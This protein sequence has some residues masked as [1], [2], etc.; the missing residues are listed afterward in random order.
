MIPIQNTDLDVM[1]AIHYNSILDHLK[2]TR[3]KYSYGKIDNWFKSNGSHKGFQDVILADFDE[4]TKI[5]E[6]YKFSAFPDEIKYISNTLYTNY[7]ADSKRG[8]GQKNYSAASLVEL[9]D[10]KVCPYCNRNYINNINYSRKG[11]KRTC[12]IDHFYCK[13]K[14]PF[15]AISFYNLIPSC[16]TC[17]HIKSN[18]DISYSPYNNKVSSND[19]GNFNFNIKSI[20]FLYDSKYLD[21]TFDCSSLLQKNKELFHIESQY[22]IHKDVVQEIFRKKI[23]YSDSKV[24]ELYNDFQDLFQNKEEVRHLIYGDTLDQEDFLKKP[25]SKLVQ[26]IYSLI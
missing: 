4:L 15:L 20:E 17:N 11:V 5:K 18:L 12:Q 16:S 6:S 24:K 19:L 1:A 10:V 8:L 3:L 23:I 7:F 21:I 9:L 14:Y 2:N 25:L 13:E 22:A 26:N